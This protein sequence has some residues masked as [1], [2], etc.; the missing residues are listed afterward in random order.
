MM[1]KSDSVQKLKKWL[2]EGEHLQQDF[3]F[4]VSDARKIA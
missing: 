4:L 3:K 2:A 1:A